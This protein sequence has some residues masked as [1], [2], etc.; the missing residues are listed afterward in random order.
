MCH[1]RLVSLGNVK[2][3]RLNLTKRPNC[4]KTGGWKIECC[5]HS[6]GSGPFKLLCLTTAWMLDRGYKECC[7]LPGQVQLCHTTVLLAFGAG[8]WI[9]RANTTTALPIIAS[10]LS[11]S[12][13]CPSYPPSYFLPSSPCF[14]CRV[15]TPLRLRRPRLSLSF[16]SS[17][18]VAW[19]RL[20]VAVLSRL[21]H[22]SSGVPPCVV[23][24][25]RL[26]VGFR[27]VSPFVEFCFPD[28]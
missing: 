12:F 20:R 22:V 9:T 28:V 23:H 15:A 11:L 18:A 10:S 4:P 3:F 27:H 26:T 6:F 25:G 2:L 7:K 24:S 8:W 16:P 1:L 13:L 17:V 14:F 5:G 21:V 19:L